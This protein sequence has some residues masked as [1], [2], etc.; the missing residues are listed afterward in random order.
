MMGIKPPIN[1]KNFWTLPCFG[2]LRKEGTWGECPPKKL[3]MQKTSPNYPQG[4]TSSRM[5][6]LAN[7]QARPTTLVA[8]EEKK[9]RNLNLLTWIREIL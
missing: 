9:K 3:L 7:D 6:N 2:A 4:L 1:P 8:Q 5:R